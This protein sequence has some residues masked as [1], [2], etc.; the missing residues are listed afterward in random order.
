MATFH[1][2]V[3][4]ASADT[5]QQ[6][7]PAASPDNGRSSHGGQD[8]VIYDFN[9]GEDNQK[10]IEGPSTHKERVKGGKRLGKEFECRH[11]GCSK[12]YSNVEHLYKHQLNRIS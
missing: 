2:D 1:S 11:E 3:S 10:D 6:L 8:L 12:A 4:P 9:D 7:S 5:K